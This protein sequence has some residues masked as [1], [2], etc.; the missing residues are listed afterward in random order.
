MADNDNN[1]GNDFKSRAAQAEADAMEDLRLEQSA[2]RSAERRETAAQARRE[3][4]DRAMAHGAKLRGESPPPDEP[5]ASSPGSGPQ[6]R[7]PENSTKKVQT[8]GIPRN[9]FSF[10]PLDSAFSFLAGPSDTPADGSG[11][12]P[13]DESHVIPEFFNR[14]T[15]TVL[16]GAN[17]T[18][19]CLG[20]D[21]NPA[22]RT[23]NW[24]PDSL[25]R[26][27]KSGY[28][29]HMAAGAIDIVAGRMSPFPVADF[30]TGKPIVLG[31]LYNTVRSNS[32]Q[33]KRLSDGIHPGMMMDAARIYISQMTDVDEYFKISKPLKKEMVAYD[34]FGLLSYRNTKIDNPGAPASAIMLKADRV[35]MHARQNIKFITRG[36][37]ETVNSQ[38]NQIN[39]SDVGIHLV[40]NNGKKV[41][42]P[43]QDLPQ[44]PMVL[45]S[46]LEMALEQIVKLVEETTRIINNVITFQTEFNRTL[47]MHHHETAT[48]PALWNLMNAAKGISTDLALLTTGDLQCTFNKLNLAQF[49]IRFLDHESEEYI[50]SKYNT[51]N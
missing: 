34:D 23:E 15:D 37:H 25:S 7:T 9:H 11:N 17:N 32:L 21:R 36:N 51:V 40:A 46:N 31:P 29:D 19:I 5:P 24:S 6:E 27:E 16:Q 2:R 4:F 49:K 33:G 48:G 1:N 12:R 50:N 42:H 8:K 44:Q 43:D 20:R 3:D 26:S 35:R 30:G 39:A 28:S 13:L 45:G 18:L 41:T 47:A 22:D 14:E 38:G 10:K